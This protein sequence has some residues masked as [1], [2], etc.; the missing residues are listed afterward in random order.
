MYVPQVDEDR[1]KNDRRCDGARLSNYTQDEI[2]E[3]SR[4]R[5]ADDLPES[6]DDGQ[7]EPIRE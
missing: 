2:N 1:R 3:L 5:V 7:P 4:G 6:S